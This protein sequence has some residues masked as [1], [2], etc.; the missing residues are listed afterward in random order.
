MN[1]WLS[2]NTNYF[3]D[4]CKSQCQRLR[5]TVSLQ[6][7]Q[8]EIHLRFLILYMILICLFPFRMHFAIIFRQLYKL[9]IIIT[10]NSNTHIK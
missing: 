6:Y 5:K 7:S 9:L 3:E 8:Y 1:E 2:F 4:T 10:F